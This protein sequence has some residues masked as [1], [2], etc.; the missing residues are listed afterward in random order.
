[1]VFRDHISLPSR[2]V[3][4]LPGT[5][6]SENEARIGGMVVFDIRGRERLGGIAYARE[7]QAEMIRTPLHAQ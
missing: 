3:Q 5:I 1:M 2:C 4:T 6:F 7:K